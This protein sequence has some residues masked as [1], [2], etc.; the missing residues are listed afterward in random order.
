MKRRHAVLVAIALVA[1]GCAPVERAISSLAPSAAPTE[2]A[3]DEAE[4]AAAI[5]FRELVG[6]RA[7]EAW[8][9]EVAANPA[10]LRNYGVPLMPFEE[11]ELGRRAT[12]LEEIRAVVEAYAAAHGDEYA[13]SYVDQDAGGLFVVM[14]TQHVDQHDA[15]LRRLLAPDA[16]FAVRQAIFTSGELTELQERIATDDTLRDEGIFVL[17]TSADEAAGVVTVDLSTE[18]LD[19]EAFLRARFGP[20]VRA[21]VVDPTGAFLKPRGVIAGRVVD[22]AGRP[23]EAALDAKPLFAEIPMDAMGIGTQRDGTFVLPDQLVGRWRITATAEGYE[24]GSG[25]VDVA[26][27]RVSRVEIVLRPS[28]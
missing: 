16:R 4:I 1:A 17:A 20:A 18:R 28:P 6:L 22:E 25:E 5:E 11:A 12:A 15:A 27:G 24:P 3:P 23:L 19:A 10:A 21:T 8:V 13:G 2:L 9:R 26:S 14:F 7:D